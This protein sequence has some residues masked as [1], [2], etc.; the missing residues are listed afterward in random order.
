MLQ[1]EPANARGALR[2]LAEVL[3]D[4]GA[5]DLRLVTDVASLRD[6]EVALTGLEA[7]QDAL[8]HELSALRETTEDRE[9][10]LRFALGELQYRAATARTPELEA[11]MHELESRLSHALSGGE[12][13]RQLEENLAGIIA[14]RGAAL[15]QAIAAYDRLERVVEEVLP[16]YASNAAVAPLAARLAM[17]KRQP[18]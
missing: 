5:N 11:Q 3:L 6:Q 7:A 8:E 15:E 2:Q 13:M 18:R 12:R 17:V 4:A 9:T 16:G 1:Q 10:Q 14:S